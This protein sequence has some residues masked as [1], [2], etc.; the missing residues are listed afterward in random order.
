MM[1][2]PAR[3]TAKLASIRIAQIFSSARKG[4][5]LHCVDPAVVLH[6]GSD[7]P[8]SREKMQEL[9][10]NRAPVIWIGG[11]EPLHH[12]GVG[13]FVR[14]LARGGRFV[15]LET[16]GTFLRRRLHEFQPLPRLFLTVRLK[17]SEDSGSALALEG[18]R[19]ARLSGFF[20]VLHSPVHQEADLARLPSLRALLLENDVDGWLVTA[21]TAEEAFRCKTAQARRL[22]PSHFW[23]QFSENVEQA[24]L[25]ERVSKDAHVSLAEKPRAK[26]REEGVGIA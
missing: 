20:T 13:H 26:P 25:A 18:L 6:P 17:S 19:A 12:P 14:A 2:L 7:A 9:I 3:L 10:A 24:L 8:V 23:R 1:R 21:G 4:S 22:I 15:F 11:S 16:D 5:L